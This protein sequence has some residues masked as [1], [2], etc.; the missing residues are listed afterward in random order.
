MQRLNRNERCLD[1]APVCCQT[2]LKQVHR[3]MMRMRRSVQSAY[4]LMT[5]FSFNI[6]ALHGNS[7]IAWP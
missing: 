2:R 1:V 4:S 7:P 5:R 3:A 6:D